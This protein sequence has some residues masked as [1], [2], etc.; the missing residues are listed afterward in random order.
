MIQ[1]SYIKEIERV[2]KQQALLAEEN[3]VTEASQEASAM[4]TATSNGPFFATHKRAKERKGYSSLR[5]QD[6][7]GSGS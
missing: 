7:I 6:S 3:K 5:R 1:E 2:K 4:A